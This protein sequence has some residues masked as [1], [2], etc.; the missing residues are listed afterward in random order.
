MLRQKKLLPYIFIIPLIFIL[1]GYVIYPLFTTFLDSIYI[2]GNFTLESYKSFFS[3]EKASNIEALLTSIYI[4]VLSVISCGIVGVSLAFLLTRYEFPGRKVLSS[5]A[6]LP[7]ALPPLVGVFSFVF[8]FG[9]SGIIPRALKALFALQEVPFRLKGIPGV[10]TVHTFTMYVYFYMLA[11]DAFMKLDPSIEEAA[12]NL[13]ANRGTVFRKIVLPMITPALVAA[14]LLVFMVSMASY[15]APLIFG[16]ERTLTMQIYISRTNGDLSMAATQSSILSMV[17]IMFLFLMRW[18]QSRG[19]YRSQSKGVAVHRTEIKNPIVKYISGFLSLFLVTILLLPI[20]TIILVS[21][22][23]DSAWTV[24]ILPP[25]YTLEN[26]VKLFN[27]PR[28]W[29]PIKN[30]LVMSGIAT[31]GNI[32]FGVAAAYAIH[33]LKF[34]GK[35]LIDVAI[36]LPWALPGTVIGINLI[37]AFNRPTI[38]SANKILVGTFWIMP[39]A[40]FVRHLPLVFRSSSASFMQLDPAI[41]EAAYNLGASRGYTFRKIVFPLIFGGILSGALLGFVQGIG[42]FVA[43]VLLYTARSRPISVAVYEH[44]YKFELGTACAYGVLQIILILIVLIVTGEF[45]K[46]ETNSAF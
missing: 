34:R 18:Y 3:L 20:L 25:K 38:F 37:T 46:G 16:V 15:T 11:S 7:M 22:S 6:V 42:E 30:S 33:R 24:Q 32:I 5:L 13:G 1:I 19:F 35:P 14:S 41:E 44:M 4:S 21:F 8:L 29:N 10:I 39:L 40:Y 12:Y 31:V 2:D 28:T 26:Y 45:S 43:S 17:S 9:E 23:V 27:N 36:M